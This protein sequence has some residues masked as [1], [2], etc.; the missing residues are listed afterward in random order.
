MLSS[1]KIYI[2]IMTVMM[3]PAIP[4]FWVFIHTITPRV[5]RVVKKKWQKAR[6]APFSMLIIPLP[7]II[8]GII[9]YLICHW[10]LI[11]PDYL[12][13]F[14]F[15]LTLMG[16]LL[17][18]AGMVLHIWT[19]LLLGITGLIGI[20]ELEGEGKLITEGPFSLVRHPTYLAHTMIFSGIFLFTGIISTGVIT[21]LDVLVVNMII[22]PLE[23]KE[24]LHRFGKEYEEYRK[25]IPRIIP[26]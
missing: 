4:I 10:N 16:A 22:I 9:A 23:E 21:L 18:F 20:P 1:L 2:A 15:I 14:P 26:F 3:W 6:P 11:M 19:G 17:L 13:R 12:I 25:R 7:V 5:S 24:L 8:W